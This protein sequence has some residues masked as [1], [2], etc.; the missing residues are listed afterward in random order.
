MMVSMKGQPERYA[1]FKPMWHLST[2]T[3][4]SPCEQ[5]PWRG[6]THEEFSS[7]QRKL[8]TPCVDSSVGDSSLGSGYILFAVLM[9]Q[10]GFAFGDTFLTGWICSPYLLNSLQTTFYAAEPTMVWDVVERARGEIWLQ[11]MRC[12]VP[13]ILIILILHCSERSNRPFAHLCWNHLLFEQ[14]SGHP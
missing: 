10:Y 5:Q 1:C 8:L 4:Q 13:S 9:V 14:L 12:K 3:S 11:F 2:H 6:G 7:M